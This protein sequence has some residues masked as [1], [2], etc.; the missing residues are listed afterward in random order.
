VNYHG[1]KNLVWV[2]TPDPSDD[3]LDWFP[4]EDVVDIIGLDIY[5]QI[6]D[7]SPQSPAFEKVRTVFQGS[8]IIALSECGSIPDAEKSWDYGAPWSFFMTW[9]HEFT[10]PTEEKP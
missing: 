9:Y 2:W 4:G 10:I 7:H 8:K 5:P 1:I 6:G 3:A